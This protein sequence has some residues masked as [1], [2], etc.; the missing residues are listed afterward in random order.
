VGL[1]C[2]IEITNVHIAV[3]VPAMT[4]SHSANSPEIEPLTA[5]QGRILALAWPIMLSNITVP[6]LGLVDTAI[7]GHL[8]DV[9]YL[10]AVAIGSQLFT[11]MLWSFGF[12][13]M[14]TTALTAQAY[15]RDTI[16]QEVNGVFDVLKNALWLALPLALLIAVIAQFMIPW[17]LPLFGDTQISNNS[18]LQTHAQQ[19]IEIRL[20][21]VP[22][23]LLQYTLVGW[24]IGLG[25]TR[26][27]LLMLT[28]ANLVNAL[29][30]YLFVYHLNMTSDGV[31]WGSVIGDYSAS[32][33]GVI[34]VWRYY[35]QNHQ[36][37][38]SSISSAVLWLQRP[39][40]QAI[41]PLVRINHQLFIRTLCLLS[42]FAFFTAQ[43]ARQGEEILA[44]NAVFITLLLLISNALD[45]FAHATESLIGQALG[46]AR[47]DLLKR[48]LWLSG[49]NM[50]TM[51]ALL[52]I[53]FFSF[54]PTLLSVLTNNP[55]LL[56]RL[57]EYQ[58]FLFLLPLVGVASYWLD[59]IFIGAA[60]TA[61]MRNAMLAAALL[62]FLPLWWLLL[63][64]SNYGLWLAF[65]GFL[66][67]RALFMLHGF[68]TLWRYPKKF[69]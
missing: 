24:F 4:P 7:L 13:R 56:P 40:W 9:T 6:L 10:G 31:A 5:T 28:S 42:V 45:G 1:R 52:S 50:V 16:T 68:L 38:S 39:H 49:S 53:G 33:I 27:P 25:K 15:G 66:V 34:C 62:V 26:I 3:I 21:S 17:L 37:N 41:A 51:A 55:G 22:A 58:G 12:L 23:V 63:P 65:Y 67:A 69:M 57:E 64:F 35:Q 36:N 20:F 48:I 19:Y 46:C 61:L 30:D 60:R 59:G 32:I 8:D 29:L 54:G 47:A 18:L 44:V 2:G 14:G 43:G 11:F